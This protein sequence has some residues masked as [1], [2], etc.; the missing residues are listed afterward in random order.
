MKYIETSHQSFQRYI[1]NKYHPLL[2][3]NNSSVPTYTNKIFNYNIFSTK[4]HLIYSRLDHSKIS[5]KYFHGI[6]TI[7]LPCRKIVTYIT[8]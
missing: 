8:K 6:Y 7:R 5:D 4:P 2:I 3:P 1:N